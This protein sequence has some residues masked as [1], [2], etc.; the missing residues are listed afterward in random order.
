MEIEI[1]HLEKADV[2]GI[3]AIY[4]QLHVVNGMLQLPYQSND[5]WN[6]RL[7]NLGK[8][9]IG[10][11]ALVEG[12]IV[13]Q[14][15]LHTIDNPRR[16]HVATIVIAVCSSVQGKGVANALMVAGVDLCDNW[17]NVSRI[18]LQVFTDN[19]RA[20]DL[21]KRHDFKI[22]GELVNYGFRDGKYVNAYAMARVR[23]TTV[24]L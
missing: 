18:E 4:D 1:R 3:K 17:L 24:T 5:T 16:K 22:E 19:E 13:G 21:Y 9:F 10:L 15:G 12:K 7:E 20:I 6:S 8:N 23:P 14:L 2:P 11:V